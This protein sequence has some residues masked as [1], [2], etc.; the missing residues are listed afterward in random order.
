MPNH[1]QST[2]LATS[3]ENN[4]YTLVVKHMNYKIDDYDDEGEISHQR[5]CIRKDPPLKGICPA[6]EQRH[7]RANQ[8]GMSP[9]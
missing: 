8:M 4:K 3:S 7:V 9:P 2:F 6:S 1:F 5:A